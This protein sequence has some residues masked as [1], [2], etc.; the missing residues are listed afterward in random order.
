[1]SAALQ[2]LDEVESNF[3]APVENEDQDHTGR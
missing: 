3:E 1:M 2:I